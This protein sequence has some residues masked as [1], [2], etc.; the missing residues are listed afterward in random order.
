MKCEKCGRETDFVV[1]A[2]LEWFVKDD[3]KTLFIEGLSPAMRK[4]ALCVG[5]F[6]RC[7]EIFK[8]EGE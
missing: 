8:K 3:W 2:K 7:A 4:R 5:C 6:D 1:I